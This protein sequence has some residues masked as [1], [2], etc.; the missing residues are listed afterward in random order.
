MRAGVAL[1]VGGAHLSCGTRK[2]MRNV[3]MGGIRLYPL[4]ILGRIGCKALLITRLWH[5]PQTSLR[6][7]TH[8]AGAVRDDA[9][10]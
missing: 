8:G 9:F 4:V 10:K 3:Q 2:C 6:Q 1:L 7:V 5:V